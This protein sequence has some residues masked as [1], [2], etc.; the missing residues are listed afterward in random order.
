MVWEVS[1]SG[2]EDVS[3]VGE[4]SVVLPLALENGEE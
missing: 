1:T 2:A 3:V 4:A